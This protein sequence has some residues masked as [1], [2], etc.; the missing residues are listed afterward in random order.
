M[1]VIDSKNWLSELAIGQE[2]LL[3]ELWLETLA[4][5]T[6]AMYWPP[7]CSTFQTLRNLMTTLQEVER[8]ILYAYHVRQLADETLDRLAE[9]GWLKSGY[10]DDLNVLR[11]LLVRLRDIHKRDEKLGN[12]EERSRKVSQWEA[13][14]T[15]SSFFRAF[16]SKVERDGLIGQ[17][18][19]HVNQLTANAATPFDVLCR[20]VGEFTN[21]LVHLGHSRDHLHGRMLGAVLKQPVAPLPNPPLLDRFDT[22]RSLGQRMAGGC[23][24]LFMVAAR[25][26]VPDSDNIRFVNKVPATFPL[27]A[28]SPFLKTQKRFAVVNVDFTLDRRT[29]SEQ[30]YRHLLRY[31]HSTRL[32]HFEFERSV[33]RRAVVRV[34]SGNTQEV[35]GSWRLPHCEL[36]NDDL[37]YDMA[38]E[39]RNESTFAELDRVLYWLEQARRWDD[40]GQLIAL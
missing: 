23:E 26:T 22:A 3:I 36:H 17:Q 18:V 2:R 12:D 40:V 5:D 4:S 28:G 32:D 27:L 7:V 20:A 21:D 8:D 31:L 19:D 33:V 35:T 37:F 1:F 11:D 25:A 39:G 24:V 6:S 9:C 14:K 15:A 30:A 13:R 29:A 38:K 16:L 10:S 34:A